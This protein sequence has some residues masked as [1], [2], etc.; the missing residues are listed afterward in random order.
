MKAVGAST[1]GPGALLIAIV[2]ALGVAASPA[3]AAKPKRGP[4]NATI[5]VDAA[6]TA[7]AR[8]TVLAGGQLSVST[9]KGTKVTVKFPPGSVTADTDV[10]AT[11]VTALGSRFT[12]KG[13][14]AGVQLQPEGLQLRTP[15]TV[16]FARLGKAPKRTRL[17]FLGT[18]GDGKS[19]HLIPPPSKLKGTG[20]QRRFVPT[21]R[22]VVSIT[23]F[24]TVDAVDLS[25]ATM[26]DITAL[27]YP[28]TGVDRLSQEI[29]RVLKDPD[30]TW[31]DLADAYERERVR[32]IDPLVKLSMAALQTTCSVKAIGRAQATMRIALSFSSQMAVLG[33]GRESSIPLLGSMLTQAAVCMGTLCPASGNPAAATYFVTLAHQL[34]L[35]GAGSEA[36]HHALFENMQRCGAYEVR[37]DARL[38]QANPFDNFSFQVTG[39][40]KVLPTLTV[41]A[42]AQAPRGALTYVRT[43]GTG[44]GP[45]TSVSIS[46]TT[47]GELELTDVKFAPF[48]PE[49][50]TAAPMLSVTLGITKTPS[51][52]YHSVFA[53]DDGACTGQPPDFDLFQW[54]D[55]LGAE[56]PGLI[57]PGADF[58]RD[59]PPVFALAVYSPHTISAAGGTLSENT[60]IEIVHTPLPQVPLPS[61]G[62]E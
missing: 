45:C 16:S 1:T 61:P 21:G 55:D 13:L 10:R 15:A 37:L 23:H 2:L 53:N 3:S 42:N 5:K 52:T 18:R 54:A 8:I 19:L 47:P 14:L 29:S 22:P 31:D 27:L 58:L 36:F 57:F 40:V 43:S 49:K 33:L 56:H 24:S 7:T 51:E 46:R 44:E 50:P 35:L 38:D 41:E 25:E 59:A 34:Q 48:D 30:H 9:R 12:R 26:D 60:K 6:R 62:I 11:L 32:F 28:E 20:K 17:T 4:V 39:T